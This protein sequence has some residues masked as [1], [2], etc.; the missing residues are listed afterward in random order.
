MIA[1]VSQPAGITK[2]VAQNGGHDEGRV[3]AGRKTDRQHGLIGASD[4]LI[5]PSELGRDALRDKLR[6]YKKGNQ[7]K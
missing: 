7:N 4:D 6:S 5:G 3:E 2:K 1:G